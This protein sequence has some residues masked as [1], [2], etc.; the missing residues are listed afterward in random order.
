M[1]EDIYRLTRAIDPTR[2]V[3]D[4]S[5]D[6]HVRTDIWS[7]H[8]YERDPKKL[9]AQ[10]TFHK[11]REPY[12][13]QADKP[14]LARYDGQPYMVDEFGGL[15]WIRPEERSTSWGYG[16]NIDTL[17]DFYR[18]L[19]DEV[20]ALRQCPNVV[21]FCY[22][23]I[24]DVEQEKNGIYY[25]DRSPKFDTA[26]IRAIFERIPSIIASPRPLPVYEP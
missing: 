16:S 19:Q 6:G 5:G 1:V 25:Y 22:T 14:F 21:G 12:R 20:D 13:N 17:D 18:I 23:Q 7:V 4:V 15:P 2:P 3:N 24:T 26:R 10:F 9:V 8:N 11:G